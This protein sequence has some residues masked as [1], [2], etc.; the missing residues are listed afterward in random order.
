MFS[1]THR[2]RYS[3]SDILKTTRE[4]LRIK[5]NK[6]KV[7]DR[8]LAYIVFTGH[9]LILQVVAICSH[10]TKRILDTVIFTFRSVIYSPNLNAVV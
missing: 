7:E 2:D 4:P 1:I 6:N 3:P 8:I 5:Q 9:L 10:F